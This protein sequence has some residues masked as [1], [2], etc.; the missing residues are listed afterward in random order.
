MTRSLAYSL[1]ALPLAIAATTCVSGAVEA[2][3][4]R[5]TL[6]PGSVTPPPT[7]IRPDTQYRHPSQTPQFRD[8]TNAPGGVTVDVARRRRW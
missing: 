3:G 7:V 8:A 5:I 1:F 6:P 2:A 4:K